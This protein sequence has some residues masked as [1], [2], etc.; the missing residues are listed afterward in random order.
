MVSI[1]YLHCCL[2]GG[3]VAPKISLKDNAYWNTDI[4]FLISPINVMGRPHFACVKHNIPIIAVKE[5]KT[6]LKD[7]M[8]NNVII[9]EN[10]LDENL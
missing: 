8:P 3:H 2:K 6:T 9:A 10:Y 5:N 4:D 7:K 1:C